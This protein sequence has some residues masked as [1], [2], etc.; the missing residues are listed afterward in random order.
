M[1]LFYT[2]NA[3]ADNNV[4]GSDEGQPPYDYPHKPTENMTIKGT[5]NPETS[6][7]RA[8]TMANAAYEAAHG[9]KAPAAPDSA[10]KYVAGR[11][12]DGTHGGQDAQLAAAAQ[13]PAGTEA[14][15]TKSNPHGPTDGEGYDLDQI[16]QQNK[17][18]RAAQNAP[19]TQKLK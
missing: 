11:M 14:D 13:P 19:R 10:E 7:S 1:K 15:R 5:K 4:T 16:C 17:A 2:Y 6:I 9:A 3:Y 18:N 12:A 8:E